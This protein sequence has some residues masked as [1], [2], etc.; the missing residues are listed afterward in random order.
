MLLKKTENNK[1]LS[2][3]IQSISV[4]KRACILIFV[5]GIIGAAIKAID[6]EI[7]I[8]KC[9]NLKMCL[10][11]NSSE[12]RIMSMGVGACAGMVAATFISIPAILIKVAINL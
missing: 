12:K 9:L 1:N 5:M 7:A 4:T 10:N 3:I 11:T 2:C 8:Q 6:T